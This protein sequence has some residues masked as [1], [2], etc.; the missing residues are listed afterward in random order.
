[1]SN[2]KIEIGVHLK[3]AGQAATDAQ[4][5]AGG[6]KDIGSAAQQADKGSQSLANGAKQAESAV[7]SLGKRGSA[8]KDVYEGLTQVMNGGTGAVFGLAKAW[9]N[10]TAAMR[11]NP[12]TAIGAAI[13]ALGP[14]L[15]ALGQKLFGVSTAAEESAGKTQS[16]FAET[17]T[18]G[19]KLNEIKFE[20]FKQELDD[21][22]TR[23]EAAAQFVQ[24]IYD[25]Q[26]KIAQARMG[27]DLATID[28]DPNLTPEQ[29]KQRTADVKKRYAAL[30]LVR[31]DERSEELMGI[32]ERTA[33]E[34][35]AK[36]DEAAATLE[37]QRARVEANRRAPEDRDLVEKELRRQ[38]SDLDARNVDQSGLDPDAPRLTREAASIRETLKYIEARNQTAKSPAAK[39]SEKVITDARDKAEQAAKES[40]AR[41]KKAEAELAQAQRLKSVDDTTKP[42][43]RGLDQQ[44]EGVE[45]RDR[46]RQSLGT[47]G[48]GIREA[49]GDAKF[50]PERLD[51]RFYHD[52]GLRERDRAAVGSRNARNQAGFS[53][54]VSKAERIAE[55]LG[56]GKN[57]GAEARELDAILTRIGNQIDQS[58]RSQLAP[59]VNALRQ[60]ETRLKSVESRQF[61]GSRQ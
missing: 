45:D 14:L 17:K 28:A 3:G 22:S 24:K 55:Q 13:L 41:A 9:H 58:S 33:K 7:D 31:E 44:K 36:A 50:Q 11:A 27:L 57:D 4:S 6:L 15:F 25:T 32:K 20:A 59:L 16:A 61:N 21:I 52:A 38:L 56:D 51:E 12:F 5:V 40:A 54:A 34:T 49:L 23:A 42:I 46:R 48:K 2:E 53:D 26:T 19:E 60:L 35:R 47:L 39:D 37:Q 8:A 29:K 30:G 43:I 18:A 1:M 10:L